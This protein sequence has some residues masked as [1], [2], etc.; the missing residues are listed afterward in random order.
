MSDLY[1]VLRRR[2]ED[3]T[4]WVEIGTPTLHNA[5][6]ALGLSYEA[7]GRKLN[8]A[9]KTWERWEKA[10]RVPRHDLH[11]VADVL[12]LEID[13]PKRTQV[14]VAEEPRPEEGRLDRLEVAAE[15]TTATLEHL[16]EG[17]VQ[18]LARLDDRADQTS[19]G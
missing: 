15:K 9:A 5:R 17:I 16:E 13:W 1:L 19:S 12:D 6:K 4:D 14:S 2:L 11:R 7:M 10:G 3:V 18:I 8:V